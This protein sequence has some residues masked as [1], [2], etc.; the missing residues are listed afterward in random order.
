[1]K[2]EIVAASLPHTRVRISYQ[3]TPS[4]YLCN[5]H[6]HDEIELLRV[7]KGHLKCSVGDEFYSA[8][9]GDVIFVN[10]RVP[11][12]VM[13]DGEG[14][15]QILVQYKIDDFVDNSRSKIGTVL[16]RFSEYSDRQCFVITSC[17]ELCENIDS[18]HKEFVSRDI[19]C[20]EYVKAGIYSS[21]ACLIRRRVIE[22]NNK[23]L[24]NPN[25]IKIMPALEYID[26]NY[27]KDISL[28]DIS[29]VLNI[30]PSYFCRL[31]KT[32]TG[33]SFCEYLNF[34]RISKSEKLFKSSERSIME[35]AMDVGFSSVTYFNRM[36][37]KVKGCTPSVYRKAQNTSV[38]GEII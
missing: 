21:I 15:E 1:M 6:L 24:T 22:N 36:F 2:N 10:S 9:A 13:C 35:I 33:A 16:A 14:S 32:A 27:A 23:I 8:T 28:E 11:H 5:V 29:G 7:V 37:K 25:I 17:P 31:F 12:A 4:D 19:G 18:M 30:N 38:L 3:K 34:V 26:E 20:E